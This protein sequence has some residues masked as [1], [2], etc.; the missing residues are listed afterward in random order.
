MKLVLLHSPLTGPLTWQKVAPLLRAMGHDVCV[1][2]YRAVLAG[3]APYYDRIV[4]DIAHQAGQSSIL[5]VHSGAGALVPALAVPLRLNAAIFVDALL[6]HPG[7]AW[8]DTVPADMKAKLLGRARDGKL[9]Q[10]SAWWPQGAIAAMIGDADL[11]DD[12]ERA[13]NAVPLAYLQEKAPPADLPVSLA[14]GYLQLSVGYDAEATMAERQGWPTRRLALHHL[15]AMTD[16]ETVAGALGG[17]MNAG[18]AAR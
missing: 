1:P 3:P 18:P 6:P 14:C 11:Y 12:F 5:I 15:A 10:W 4:R 13:L 17:L 7:L 8:F 16:C 9:P 2:D